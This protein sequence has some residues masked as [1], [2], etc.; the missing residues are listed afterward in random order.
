MKT[1]QAHESHGPDVKLYM[2]VFGALAVLTVVTVLVSKFQLEHPWNIVV[3]LLIATIK[4][5]LVAAVFM[6]L[7]GEHKFIYWVLGT[8]FL[9]AAL[10]VL[11]F[12]DSIATANRRIAA[13]VT[14]EGKVEHANVP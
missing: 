14:S 13:P 5:G 7:K 4:A 8:T 12:I 1:S 9:A 11:P 10:F 3:G 2:L 6:H